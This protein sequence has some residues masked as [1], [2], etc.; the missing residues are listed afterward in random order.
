MRIRIWNQHN[1]HLN[2]FAESA[3]REPGGTPCEHGSDDT[4]DHWSLGSGTSVTTTRTLSQNLLLGKK[5]IEGNP[6]RRAQR[7][8]IRRSPGRF[9]RFRPDIENS[10]R[11]NRAHAACV[12]ANET[13]RFPG[14]GRWRSFPPN[15]RLM[16]YVIYYMLL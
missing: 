1:N 7:E 2:T 5:L 8:R 13:K 3:A 9:G 6:R 16:L 14:W 10:S 4:P 15:L 12:R 11:E